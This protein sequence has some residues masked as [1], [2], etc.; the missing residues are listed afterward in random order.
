MISCICVGLSIYIF[1][2]VVNK[3]AAWIFILVPC[4]TMNASLFLYASTQPWQCF[5]FQ[6]FYR[7]L[8]STLF[9]TPQ[10]IV[11]EVGGIFVIFVFEISKFTTGLS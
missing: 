8:R 4:A 5:F 11:H 9:T 1:P 2:S 10:L 7:I 6:Y 3:S